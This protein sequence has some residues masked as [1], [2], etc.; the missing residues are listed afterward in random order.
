MKNQYLNVS[1]H[2]KEEGGHVRS[3]Y[4]QTSCFGGSIQFNN[5]SILKHDNI[6]IKVLFLKDA[7]N[8]FDFC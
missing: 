6:S 5:T 4:C 7:K 2:N 3:K 1:M 8:V